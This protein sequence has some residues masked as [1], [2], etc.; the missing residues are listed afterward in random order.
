MSDM[1]RTLHLCIPAASTPPV[2]RRLFHIGACSA[3]PLLGIFFNPT[4]MVALLAT[5]S[6]LALLV[7][8]S[9]LRVPGLNQVLVRW[10]RPILKETE[11]RRI[12]GA[13]YIAVSALVAFLV[14][15]KP[16]AIVALFFLSLGD[17]V[18]ALVGS[19]I[20]G[21]RFLGKSPVGTLAFLAVGVAVA[22]L[23]SVAGVVPFHW[24]LA[25]GAAVAAIVELAPSILDDNLTIPLVSG[26]AM[27]W[28]G[29]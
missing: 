16:V 29:V 14:F 9:R 15:D 8:V 1:Q 12:T 18:A 13:T 10:L 3:I 28:M 7:E 24:A 5:L 6:G 25:A 17:P 21:V 23:V 20:G 22:S 26:A 2:W 11:D 19:R 27:T 4:V